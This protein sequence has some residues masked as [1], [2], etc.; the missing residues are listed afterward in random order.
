MIS[1]LFRPASTSKIA[2]W[3]HIRLKKSAD[4]VHVHLRVC[5]QVYEFNFNSDRRASCVVT[6]L[7]A[8]FVNGLDY[9]PAVFG[10]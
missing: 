5:D 3:M 8:K 2:P 1:N 10:W 6:M 7:G 9:T 4:D